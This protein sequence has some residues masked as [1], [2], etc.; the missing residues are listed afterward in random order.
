LAQEQRQHQR[1]NVMFYIRWKLPAGMSDEDKQDAIE[2]IEKALDELPPSAS[3]KEMESVRDEI[4]SE[5]EADYSA[6]KKA[7]DR[8]AERA[9]QKAHLVAVGLQ[10]IPA[11]AQRLLRDYEYDRR[12]TALHIELRVKPEIKKFLEDELAGNEDE[13]GVVRMVYQEMREIEGC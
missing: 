4:V 1:K 8:K 13:R 7:A 2:E 12:E 3:E 5:Y 9:K 6:K 11:N 10:S